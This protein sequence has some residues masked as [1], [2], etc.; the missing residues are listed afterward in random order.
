MR[1][2]HP[3]KKKDVDNKYGQNHYGFLN[4]P[5]KSVFQIKDVL[6]SAL[7]IRL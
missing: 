3:N 2:S 5:S 7:L 1:W 6:E 4:F